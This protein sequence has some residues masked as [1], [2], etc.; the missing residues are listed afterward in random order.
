MLASMGDHLLVRTSDWE[1]SKLSTEFL[2]QVASLRISLSV[3][4]DVA[5]ESIQ[6]A[7][8]ANRVITPPVMDAESSRRP[9]SSKRVGERTKEKKSHDANDAGAS[10]EEIPTISALTSDRRTRKQDATAGDTVLTSAGPYS[11]P[12]PNDHCHCYPRSPRQTEP[13]PTY[14]LPH[15]QW[16]MVQVVVRPEFRSEIDQ[17]HHRTTYGSYYNEGQHTTMHGSSSALTSYFADPDIHSE[18]F[19]VPSHPELLL[20]LNRFS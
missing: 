7:S 20:Y 2:W 15:A 14:A 17:S 18:Y 8:G 5:E 1:I 9:L 4:R 10:S 3:N 6:S 16:P 19:V 12:R 11:A 13:F